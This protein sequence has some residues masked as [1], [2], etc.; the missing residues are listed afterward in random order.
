M[1][2]PFQP[3]W[4]LRSAH[5][6]TVW[7]RMVRSRRAVPLRREVLTTPDDDDLVVDHLDTPVRDRSLRYILVHGL[8]GSSNSVYM[9]GMLGVIARRGF[10]ATAINFRSCARDPQN[11][12]RMLPNR[13]P[14]FYHSG[15]TGDFD[16][17]ARTLVAREPDVTFVA[18][19]ASL[20]GNQLL[21][22]LGEHPGQTL[23]HAAAAMSVPLDL[24]AGAAHLE[25]GWGPV[26]VERFLKTLRPKVASVWQRFPEVRGMLDMDRTVRAR[27]FREFDDAATAPL[28]GMRDAD[29]YYATCSSLHF[30]G[31]IDTPAL[32]LTAKDD[33]FVPPPVPELA[34]AAAS[35]FV[36]FRVTERGG[37]VGF[38]AGATPWDC[39]YWAE[40]LL[41]DWLANAADKRQSLA[42]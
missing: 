14:R 25:Q 8:E 20:G 11:L 39:H 33:P 18:A 10:A 26:Y 15:E 24:A 22:W 9:Q 3:A 5:L 28:H 6:Q 41:V 37:H 32:V 31:R 23:I 29:D 30:L 35:S 16:F 27:T 19:G 21:K 12:Q 38:V 42:S 4:F 13:R 40:D 17:V 1:P 36:D 2:N 34:R 7:G